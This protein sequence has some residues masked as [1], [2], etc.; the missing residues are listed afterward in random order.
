[1]RKKA[2]YY[3][4]NKTQKRPWVAGCGYSV[5][6]HLQAQA[7]TLW[8]PAILGRQAEIQQRSMRITLR[9]Q[10]QKFVPV[11]ATEAQPSVCHLPCACNDCDSHL[12]NHPGHSCVFS[13]KRATIICIHSMRFSTRHATIICIHSMRKCKHLWLG[14]DCWH[15]CMSCTLLLWNVPRCLCKGWKS[16]GNG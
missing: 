10:K 9:L 6:S 1:M 2:V 16:S 14:N 13:T 8:F 5:I 12:G 7:K 4:K 15:Q 3:L 11:C